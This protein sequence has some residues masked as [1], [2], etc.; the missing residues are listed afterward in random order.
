MYVINILDRTG[1][2]LIPVPVPARLMARPSPVRSL[3]RPAGQ[4]SGRTGSGRAAGPWAK[5][6]SLILIYPEFTFLVQ[7]KKKYNCKYICRKRKDNLLHL[8]P[9]S[10]WWTDFW[11]PRS[12]L[13]LSDTESSLVLNR[14]VFCFETT[15]ATLSIILFTKFSAAFSDFSGMSDTSYSTLKNPEKKRTQ[16]WEQ[17]TGHRIIDYLLYW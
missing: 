1:L 17:W 10:I 5:L 7:F 4:L 8:P 15:S 6:P 16:Q 13:T 12:L 2:S 14:T 3:F 11:R 9:P